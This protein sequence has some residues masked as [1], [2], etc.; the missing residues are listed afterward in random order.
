MS[1]AEHRTDTMRSGDVALFYRAFGQRGAT[2]I[3]IVHGLSYFSY[4]WIDIAATLSAGREVVAMDMRGFGESGWSVAKNYGIGDFSADII[5]LIDHLGWD[6][7]ILMGHSMGGRN[8]T[9]CAAE[10]PARV[11]RLVLVDYSPQNAPAGSNRVA[12]MVANVPERFAT[13]DDG[14]AYFGKDAGDPKVRA[15]YEA[16]L[17]KLDDGYI[18][19]RDT[20]HRDRFQKVLAGEGS[21]GGPDMWDSL[22]RVRCPIL[23]LR[24]TRSDMFAP[25][26]AEKVK[27]TNANL[28]LV[29]VDASHDVAGDAPDALIAEVT[30][31]LSKGT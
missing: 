19:R 2:P 13:L 12:T 10:N 26:T 25:E 20:F 24:G 11:E 1:T 15:R 29:E 27:S 28:T 23:T 30:S 14:I 8:C 31:F 5:N 3:L 21:G 9:W 7:V 17:K 22:A 18:V 6:S 16:Y 4:D